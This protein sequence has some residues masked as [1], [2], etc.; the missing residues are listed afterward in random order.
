[1]PVSFK[2][3]L[4]ARPLVPINAHTAGTNDANPIC[5]APRFRS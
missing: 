1:L 2:K 4:E 3:R 5:L